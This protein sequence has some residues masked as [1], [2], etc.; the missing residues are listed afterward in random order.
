MKPQNLTRAHRAHTRRAGWAMLAYAA[1][2]VPSVYAIAHHW[3]GQPW[4]TLLA[5]FSAMPV[6]GM[7]A[8]YGRYLAEETDEY[9]RAQAVRRILVATTVAM[10]CAVIWGFLS[11]LG[12]MQPIAN[13]WIAVVWMA[14]QGAGAVADTLKA[15]H[16]D[17]DDGGHEGGLGGGLGGGN[18]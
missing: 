14:V 3:V 11:E 9:Q 1:I 5:I 10:C 4:Q 6:V 13:Y 2:L 15:R 17:G 7:F 12:G 18:E 8:S 16:G